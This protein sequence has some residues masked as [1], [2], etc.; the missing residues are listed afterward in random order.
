TVFDGATGGVLLDLAP[1]VPEAGGEA[2][3]ALAY[4]TND[5]Y[6]D[7]VVG[8]GPGRPGVVRVFDGQ[9]GAQLPAPLGEYT[10]FGSGFTGGVY[11]AA[12]NDPTSVTPTSATV[13]VGETVALTITPAFLMDLGYGGFADLFVDWDG[14]TGLNSWTGSSPW[15][16]YGVFVAPGVYTVDVYTSSFVFTNPEMTEFTS[17]DHHVYVTVTVGTS[18]PPPPPPPPPPDPLPVV[19]VYDVTTPHPEPATVDAVNGSFLLHR[20][21]PTDDPLTVS[22]ALSGSATAD[23]DYESPGTAVT[24]PAGADSVGVEVWMLPDH[25]A[26]G[27]ETVVLTVT[28]GTGYT[29]GNVASGTMTIT[30]VTTGPIA[31]RAWLDE[32]G[33]GYADEAEAAA[34]GV[35]VTL[36][37][38][39]VGP[40]GVQALTDA[41]GRYAFTDL[42]AGP[43]T[44]RFDPLPGYVVGTPST[45]ATAVTLEFGTQQPGVDAG[46]VLAPPPPPSGT[47]VGR[48]WDDLD[49]DGA[50]DEGEPGVGGVAVRA[51]DPDTGDAATD[52][53]GPDGRYVLAFAPPGELA[54]TFTLP[55]SYPGGAR[56][57]GTVV[58]VAAG[59]VSTADVPLAPPPP[60]PP[61]AFAGLVWRDDDGDGAV[62]PDEAGLG[63]VVIRLTDGGG[64]V[65][66]M[67][68][69]P[70]GEYSFDASGLPAGDYRVEVDVPEGYGPGPTGAGRANAADESGAAP[71]VGFA[72]GGPAP[73]RASV[74]LVPGAGWKAS[75][76]P[77]VIR[78]EPVSYTTTEGVGYVQLAVRRVQGS[79][80]GVSVSYAT[81]NLTAT[82][83]ADYTATSGTLSWANGEENTVRY[84]SVPVVDDS[85]AEPAEQFFVHLSGAT[86][87]AGISTPDA[88]VTI[89][90][91][92]GYT[93]PPTSPPPTSPPPPPPPA[94]VG[95][96]VW[97]D[98]NANGKQDPGEK[99]L[100]GVTVQLLTSWGDY[101][102]SATSDA[103]GLYSISWAPGFG[104][105]YKLRL[106]LPTGYTAGRRD[107]TVGNTL[108]ND[109]TADGAGYVASYLF[110][111]GAGES[112]PNLDAGLVPPPTYLDSFLWSDTNTDGRQDSGEGGAV[113]LAVELWDHAGSYVRTAT[114]S[115]T[116]AG[117]YR[118]DITALPEGYYQLRTSLPAGKTITTPDRVSVPPAGT[119]DQVDSDLIG[120]RGGTAWTNY[121]YVDPTANLATVDGGFVPAP[122]SSQ[123]GR[124]WEDSNGDG[125]QDAA[126]I[127][128]GKFDGL[129]VSLVRGGEVVRTTTT[130]GGGLYSFTTNDLDGGDYTVRVAVPLGYRRSPYQSP[131]ATATTDSDFPYDSYNTAPGQSGIAWADVR[132]T[133]G[134]SGP[135]LDAGFRPIPRVGNLVWKDGLGGVRVGLLYPS[136]YVAWTTTAADGTYVFDNS[137][138]ALAT[139]TYRVRVVVPAGYAMTLA[140]QTADDLDSDLTSATQAYAT[141]GEFTITSGVTNLDVDAGLRPAPAAAVAGRLWRD[142]DGD[143]VQDPAAPGVPAEPGLEGRTVE[144]LNEV[145]GVAATATTSS[146]GAYSFPMETLAGGRYLVRFTLPAG[147]V[148]SP[149]NQTTDDA[150]SDVFAATGSWAET[151]LFDYTPGGGGA[152]HVDAGAMSSPGKIGDLIWGERNGNGVQDVGEAGY[153]GLLIKL[154]RNGTLVDTATTDVYGR[155]EF[156]TTGLEN[157]SGYTVEFAI[158]LNYVVGG[159]FTRVSPELRVARATLPSITSGASY[160]TVD[161]TLA[162]DPTY[163]DTR[164]PTRVAITAFATDTGYSASDRL[165][166]ATSLTLAGTAPANALVTIESPTG[167]QAR[168]SAFGVWSITLPAVGEGVLD[169]VAFSGTTTSPPFRVTVDRTPPTL[170]VLAPAA[171]PDR[172]S[173]IQVAVREPTPGQLPPAAV[174]TLDVD[175]NN[176]GDFDDTREVGYATAPVAAGQAV[177]T[178][179][180]ALP[181]G[182]TVR[183]RAQTVDAAGN[184]GTS[185]VATVRTPAE[186][187]ATTDRTPGQRSPYGGWGAD[188]TDALLS[189]GVVLTSRDLGLSG[190]ECGCQVPALG[191]DSSTADP[192]PVARMTVR[193]APN[194]PAPLSVTITLVWD[195]VTQSAVTYPGSGLAIGSEWVFAAAA[196]AGQ[197]TGRHTYTLTAAVDYPGAYPDGTAQVSGATYVVSRAASP[198]GAGWEFTNTDRLYPV[199]ASGGYP[200][201]V[202]LAYGAGG[203]AFFEATGGGFASPRGDAGTLT[204]LAGGGYRYTSPDGRSRTFDAAGRMT[205]W[206][207]ADGAETFQYA[208]DA[209]GKLATMTLPGGRVATFA[210]SGGLLRTI[211]VPGGG[212]FTLTHTGSNLTQLMDPASGFQGFA[213][214]GA[215]LTQV[216][217]GATAR[218][219]GYG[220]DGLAAEVW[221]GTD[222]RR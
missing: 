16:A 171:L 66:W 11:V 62:D 86:G 165:T 161:G 101:V 40:D 82:S 212:V 178:A 69:G 114:P 38:G 214:S 130:S 4:V 106:A 65:A 194:A 111:L 45:G 102:T 3:V 1:F 53:T 123:G 177:F 59:E 15:V 99:P 63:G 222:A 175:L 79:A 201:G 124:V 152:A 129:T 151:A 44:V 155:Y 33:D 89:S 125:K 180:R 187:F 10:P 26:E 203:W 32:D 95:N 182:A 168:A 150:D 119:D 112:N 192:A 221:T 68:T 191:Y 7:V 204:A 28:S 47:V 27:D 80:G 20:T 113:G 17:G 104:T 213:Y 132:I 169:L 24:F 195:G 21:G 131:S 35:V 18:P 93:S 154:L 208:Y 60:P 185:P 206:A 75:A 127:A 74:G 58:A 156:P 37:G 42:A 145:G 170:E 88:V 78:F 220:A 153:P 159:A 138:G 207:S 36:T 108:D 144:L 25:L 14:G 48:V 105:T 23:A 196:P 110:Q 49:A 64:T 199:A 19:T 218:G 209:G 34:A 157:G 92:D 109:F 73:A 148:P 77:G 39:S 61:P 135:T 57:V 198:F 71:R 87:G 50:W 29:L 72:P 215:R 6:A 216:T 98:G 174:A 126:E 188:P 9:T 166:A 8:S 76:G 200:A 217:R 13:G 190:A 211:A 120:H 140:D 134:V 116:T 162:L 56:V 117:S 54:A 164:A 146:V 141:T 30:D 103:N 136:G 128:S 149:P 96:Y 160:L 83:L 51:V 197:G 52:V 41:E 205:R 163:P 172:V 91:N 210:Y 142:D 202:L 158:P 46:I 139:G 189:A 55:P 121:F 31:G 70:D 100:A 84:I 118:I 81:A 107:L 181:A 184:T 173:P 183:L 90:Q 219:Y 176:D 2:R 167:P 186:V 137:P 43:Y 193:G 97:R 67:A 122:A 94:V 179:Y 22:F 85:A 12:S 115:Q 5:R 147:R 133:P 143:G